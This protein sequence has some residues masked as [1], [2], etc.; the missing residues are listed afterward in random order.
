MEE[1]IS[2]KAFSAEMA[3]R[4]IFKMDIV[5][6][7]THKNRRVPVSRT[8]VRYLNKPTTIEGRPGRVLRPTLRMVFKAD[9]LSE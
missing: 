9:L 2:S 5:K 1:S 8:K 4:G 3:I 7:P 6:A